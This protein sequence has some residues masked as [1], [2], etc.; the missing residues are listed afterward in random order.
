MKYKVYWR[1]AL[2]CDKILCDEKI[3]TSYASAHIFYRQLNDVF[4]KDREASHYSVFTNH[5]NGNLV[6]DFTN[7][8]G[9]VRTELTEVVDDYG[10]IDAAEAIELLK[11]IKKEG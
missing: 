3:F 4:I 7:N 1:L 8:L 5:V 6:L 10:C 2:P 9:Y 11:Q